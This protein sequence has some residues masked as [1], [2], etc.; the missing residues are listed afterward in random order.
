MVKGA[1]AIGISIA[2]AAG[3]GLGTS[4]VVANNIVTGSEPAIASVATGTV[5]ADPLFVSASDLHLQSGS[6]VR[7]AGNATYAPATDRDGRGRVS[8]PD[9]GAY[10]F[11]DPTTRSACTASPL[12]P[13]EPGGASYQC[14]T[15]AP[16]VCPAVPVL[17]SPTKS[18]RNVSPGPATGTQQ[19]IDFTDANKVKFK[20]TRIT[21]DLLHGVPPDGDFAPRAKVG[22]NYQRSD[23]CTNDTASVDA[24]LEPQA[25]TVP[26]GAIR[27][28]NSA[29]LS[30]VLLNTGSGADNI[31]LADGTYDNA[32]PF[33][34]C[35]YKLWSENLLGAT[36]TA[37]VSFGGQWCLDGG[38]EVHGI[39]F[40]VTDP[41]KTA[42]SSIVHAWGNSVGNIKIQDSVFD[43]N[44]SIYSGVKL[45]L[46][47]NAVLERSKFYNFR[48]IPA[49]ISD[50]AYTGHTIYGQP[51]KQMSHIIYL[52]IDGAVRE[53]PDASN[54]QGEVGLWVGNP[55]QNGVQRLKIRNTSV[56]GLHIIDNSRD[57]TFT[58]LDIDMTGPNAVQA[59]GIYV[60]HW[61]YSNT[62][63]NFAIKARAGINCE[64][65]NPEFYAY[66]AACQKV[67]ISDGVIDGTGTWTMPS[68]GVILTN[69][70]FGTTIRNVRFIGQVRAAITAYEVGANN[71]YI[72][73]DYSEIKPTAVEVSTLHPT[74]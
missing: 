42:V 73:N 36:L 24:P 29:E 58:D 74:N 31:V 48:D 28:T 32:E 65:N 60:E 45:L 56:S 33:A 66:K 16:T 54:G 57:T 5:T 41:V 11:F 15:V 44:W 63:T 61:G 52:Y 47:D 8:T 25:Y 37:G 3:S 40:D 14:S 2:S 53:V 23:F 12:D 71:V 35:H 39:N 10:E 9:I 6:P 67:T 70:T 62:L 18:N 27:V 7:D 22:L 64:W 69:G 21:G 72:D 4:M 51:V 59:V 20:N 19:Y 55:V 50:T 1:T 46:P 34:G 68:I 43:G 38:G 26:Q 17:N 49:F 13:Y 30:N